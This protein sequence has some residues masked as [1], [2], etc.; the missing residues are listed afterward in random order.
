M[1]RIVV[2]AVALAALAP[3]ASRASG[4][5]TVEILA[6]AAG[7]HV[8][9]VVRI[10]ASAP[11]GVTS[12]DFSW[13]R[14]GA[15][16]R[17]LA[18]DADGSDGWEAAWDTRPLNGRVRIRA[19]ASTGASA[20]VAVVV[21]NSRPALAA[22]VRPA[23]F[24]PN[25]DGR[26]DT[27]RITVRTD[28]LVLVHVRVLRGSGKTVRSLAKAARTRRT[29]TLRWDGR[30][31]RGRRL[32]DGPY[33]VA[34]TARDLA[35]NRTSRRRRIRVDTR[36]PRLRW[37]SRGGVAP[38]RSVTVRFHLRDASPPL[39]GRF[40]LESAYGRTMHAWRRRL[41]RG[42]GRATLSRREVR[43]T[44]PGAYRLRAVVVDAAGNRSRPYR[45]PAY[46]LDH[47]VATRVVARVDTA[48]RRVALTFD[49]CVF[50]GSWSSILHT[51]A[52]QRVKA[53]FFC[54]G[55][56]V[57]A[58]PRL[59]ARTVRAGHTV[60]SHGWDHAPLYELPY[61]QVLRR[62]RADR[63]VWWRWRGAATPYFRPVEGAFGP[64][65]LSAAAAAGYRY[66]VVWDVD[67]RDW[68]DPGVGTIVARAVGGAR[69]GSIILLH[70]KPETAAALPAI[71]GGLRARGLRPVGLDALVH[72]PRAGLSKGGWRGPRL[73]DER[74]V[75]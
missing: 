43:R 13:S 52:R 63:R 74:R 66:T 28:E 11:P 68:T 22:R 9:R 49:D 51:L 40:G 47:P 32:A 17:V 18:S 33:L 44:V 6:P 70:V 57:R 65:V 8:R 25:G 45:S 67:T 36:R 2:A 31:R 61:W 69:R 38:L 30:N 42:R 53:G 56:Q 48:G 4:A 19:T 16:W 23:S 75:H 14:D 1:T 10:T 60:G 37:R 59:A 15:A 27:A 55:K 5:E 62:L 26:K 21:D 3:F 71:I 35:G 72:S 64:T 29:F 39:R 46:R 20:T 41:T 73:A 7:A 54:P 34:V 58:Y 12:V 50:S 24:S